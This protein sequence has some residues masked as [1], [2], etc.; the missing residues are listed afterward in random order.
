MIRPILLMVLVSGT[1]IAG[2]SK[3]IWITC[4]YDCGIFGGTKGPASIVGWYVGLT[5]SF[6]AGAGLAIQ[7]VVEKRH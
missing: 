1:A 6:L 3:W 2:W 7:Y 5:L 4:G